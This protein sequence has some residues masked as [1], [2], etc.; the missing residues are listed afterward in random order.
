MRIPRYG[1]PGHRQGADL[2]P[3]LSIVAAIIVVLVFALFR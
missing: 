1:K 3:A 2:F